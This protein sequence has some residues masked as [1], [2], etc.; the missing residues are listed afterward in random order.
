MQ[1]FLWHEDSNSWIPVAPPATLENR[2]RQ[3][4]ITQQAIIE[5]IQE[6]LK[7]QERI[8][9][10]VNNLKFD[11]DKKVDLQGANDLYPDQ[12]WV[13][14]Q[15]KLGGGNSTFRHDPQRRDGAVQPAGA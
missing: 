1:L 13:L 6:S 12:A 9:R 3:G 8:N 5:Q 4:E 15:D 10:N 7:E 2:V 14:K 11:V